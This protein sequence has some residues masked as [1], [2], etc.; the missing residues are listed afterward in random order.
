MN[1]GRNKLKAIE[2]GVFAELTTLVFLDLSHNQIQTITPSNFQ[3]N[4]YLLAFKERRTSQYL[5]IL[6]K[7]SHLCSTCEQSELRFLVTH[8][9]IKN[10]FDEFSTSIVN[11]KE[12]Q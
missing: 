8:Y 6:P 12:Q 7:V 3:G 9:Q 11:L 10:I 4:A 5:K 1:L 2:D